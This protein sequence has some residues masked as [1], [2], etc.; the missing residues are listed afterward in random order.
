MFNFVRTGVL[1]AVMTA[2]FMAVGYFIGGT[3][4]M[5][6]AFGVAV[7]MNLISYWNAGKLVLSLQGARPIDQRSAPELYSM[8]ARLAQNAGLP[9]PRSTSSR[10][11]S[12]TPSPP[13]AIRRMRWLLCRAA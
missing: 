12:P 4:G 2:L 5:M 3:S 10:P 9:M 1:L 6:I 11:R 13:A 8:V 7:V